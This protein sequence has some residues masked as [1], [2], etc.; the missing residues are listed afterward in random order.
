MNAAKGGQRTTSANRKAYGRGFRSGIGRTPAV[1]LE[2]ETDQDGWVVE[3]RMRRDTCETTVPSPIPDRR[4]GCSAEG[5][6][7]IVDRFRTQRT[8][9]GTRQGKPGRTRPETRLDFQELAETS[10]TRT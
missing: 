9:V 2:G 4:V 7:P 8:I 3:V 6:V 10:C 5:G 1:D